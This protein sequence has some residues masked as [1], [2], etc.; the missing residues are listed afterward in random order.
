M[1]GKTTT[2]YPAKYAEVFDHGNLAL[3]KKLKLNDV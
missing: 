1:K 3:Y 2:H